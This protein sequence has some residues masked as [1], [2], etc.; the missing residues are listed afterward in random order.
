M[1]SI[2][3]I[4]T[5]NVVTVPKD[6]G[7]KEIIK[8]MSNSKISSVIITDNGRVTGILTERDLIKKILTSCPN[9]GKVSVDE[10]MTHDPFTVNSHTDLSEASQMMRDNNIR[11]LPI[12]DNEKLV[13]LVSQTD[14]VKETRN[15]HRKNRTFMTYQNI[16]TIIII[17][18]FI[19]LIAYFVYRKFYG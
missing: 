14:I 17:L 2:S 5:K 12:V 8:T 11:H 6:K 16:Q 3:D 18:L 15:I 1:T 10:V 7:L 4:M 19:F 13:G 9:I